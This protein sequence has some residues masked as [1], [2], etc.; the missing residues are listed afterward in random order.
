[1]EHTIAT[2]LWRIRLSIRQR[3]AKKGLYPAACLVCPG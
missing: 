3:L 1:M 2:R